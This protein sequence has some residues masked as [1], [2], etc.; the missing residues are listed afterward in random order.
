[1]AAAIASSAATG[2]PLLF[3]LGTNPSAPKAPSPKAHAADSGSKFEEKTPEPRNLELSLN[4]NL[5]E[6]FDS[7]QF[8]SVAILDSKTAQSGTHRVKIHS[9]PAVQVLLSPKSL[10]LDLSS[11]V[12]SC[13]IKF[14]TGA[15]INI[16]GGKKPLSDFLS[17]LTKNEKIQDFLSIHFKITD[18]A[19][20]SFLK[21]R[22]QKQG[23]KNS[24]SEFKLVVGTNTLTLNDFVCIQA[25]SN[26]MIEVN[27]KQHTGESAVFD[28][29]IPGLRLEAKMKSTGIEYKKEGKT[30]PDLEFILNIFEK[31]LE[32]STSKTLD[33]KAEKTADADTTRALSFSL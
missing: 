28:D 13:E 7:N 9:L 24:I 15:P 1:S 3:S 17:F 22:T 18:L 4:N 23:P 11:P 8:L 25:A 20:L 26:A 6:N 12:E 30:I 16:A 14:Q 10:K 27:G 32:A 31:Q 5:P 19:F 33:S 21:I 29:I 2:A